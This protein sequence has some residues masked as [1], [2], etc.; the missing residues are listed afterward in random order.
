MED[1]NKGHRCLLRGL[2]ALECEEFGCGSVKQTFVRFEIQQSGLS[3]LVSLCR[4][5]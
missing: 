3:G 5:F 2:L 1:G 4:Y